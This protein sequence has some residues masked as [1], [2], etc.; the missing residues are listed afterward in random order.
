MSKSQLKDV[1]P[2]L[3]HVRTRMVAQ[4]SWLFTISFCVNLLVFTQPLYMFQVLDRVIGSGNVST[5]IYLTIIAGVAIF[6]WAALDF[7]R[8]RFMSRLGIWFEQELGPEIVRSSMAM[9]IL[10]QSV[11]TSGLNHLAT[12]RTF[13]QGSAVFALIDAPAALMFIGVL[14]Y[15]H[16][17]LGLF[18]LFGAIVLF[19]SALYNDRATSKLLAETSTLHKETLK[20]AEQQISHA[21]IV[22][23]LGMTGDLVDQ[24]RRANMVVMRN[25]LITGDRSGQILAFSKFFRLFLQ[26]SILGLGAYLLLQQSL[27]AGGMIAASILLGRGLA[28]VEQSIG[29]WKTLRGAVQAWESLTQLLRVQA[30]RESVVDLPKPKGILSLEEVS[31]APPRQEKPILLNVSFTVNPGNLCALIGPSGAGKSSLCRLIVGIDAPSRGH[32]RL[33]GADVY[34]WQ[35]ADLGKHIG[36]LPQTVDLFEGT[37]A[38]NI[39]RMQTP[40]TE[41]VLAAAKL[42][43]VHDLILGL[44]DGYDTDIGREGGR[45][46]GGMRQRIGLARAL[47]GDPSLIVLDEPN[48]NLDRAGEEALIRVLAHL[49]KQNRTILLVA[50]SPNIVRGSDMVVV[51]QRGMV[52]RVGSPAQIFP[53][54]SSAS[55]IKPAPKAVDG[56]KR[57]SQAKQP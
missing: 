35:S 28:P 38:H 25:Y 43:Q 49:R 51:L 30:D 21:Q 27:T 40:D 11:G 52:Q 5:L 20:R 56:P 41:Q 9:T 34:Q 8:S 19:G 2:V 32:V 17:A 10:G 46:S 15:M 3:T 12:I 7:I 36:Y 33:D 31:Y 54:V 45:L 55:D 4:L 26:V 24:W 29:A 23:A 42:T 16:P 18:A 50:H 57:E 13:L 1:S 37:I 44:P 53:H 39:A 22:R 14:F 47:Y 6:T 48:S